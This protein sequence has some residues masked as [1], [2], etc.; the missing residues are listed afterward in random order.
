MSKAKEVI[1]LLEV[2]YKNLTDEES[3]RLDSLKSKARSKGNT[4][5]ESIE[6][7]L[8]SDII[9]NGRDGKFFVSLWHGSDSDPK[10]RQTSKGDALKIVKA[11]GIDPS[12]VKFGDK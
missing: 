9:R 7:S 2:K 5:L 10:G 8:L 6:S 3:K 11:L 4:D 1:K 12:K